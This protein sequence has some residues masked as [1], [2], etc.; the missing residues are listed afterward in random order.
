MWRE[1]LLLI[2]WDKDDILGVKN[3]Y[4]RTV[5]KMKRFFT[6]LMTIIMVVGMA[7]CKADNDKK[8]PTR[9]IQPTTAAG[10]IV[11]TVA[12]I[13][14]ID[15]DSKNIT[16]VDA[17]S[18]VQE[19]YAYNNGTEYLSKS[20]EA[21]TIAQ[22]HPGDVV[23]LH[24]NNNTFVVKKIQISE[25]DDVWVNPKV[26]AFSVDEKN[27]AMKIGKTMYYY[28]SQTLILSDGKEIDVRELNNS[29]D[30][31]SVTGYDNKI[32]SIV[33]DKGHGYL[34]LTGDSLFVGG[35]INVGG[36]LARKIEAEMLLTVTEGSYKVEVV[37]GQYKAEKYVTIKRG[38]EFVL[39]FS[40]VAANVT[41]TGNIK[42]TVDVKG[43]RLYIDGNAY[44]YSSILT[45]KTGKHD[46]RVSAEGYDDY[47]KT[48]EIKDGYQILDISMKES[49]S[50]EGTTAT[51]E[52]ETTAVE[53]ETVVSKINDV[54]VKGPVGAMVYFDGSYKGV[55]PVSFDMVTGTHVISILNKNKINSYT[56]TLAEGGDDVVYDFTDK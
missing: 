35:L 16:F 33:V 43:A 51:P 26:T 48:I 55:A 14:S 25:D 13:K 10:K 53:G 4:G 49:T 42:I 38:E 47:V 34:S 46:I 17:E 28:T 1:E 8:K 3:I 20:G 9:P 5:D 6:I 7:G 30:C 54:T 2:L 50:E 27:Q 52:K 31:L 39:D 44:N 36:V 32:V 12:V 45:L 22:I 41:Q 23:D 56:V 37:N 21:I 11:K 29:M 15:T 24:Y 40:D 18:G 19:I